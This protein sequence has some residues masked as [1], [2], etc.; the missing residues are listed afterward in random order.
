M[1]TDPQTTPGLPAARPPVTER[2]DNNTLRS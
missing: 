2:T 1:V